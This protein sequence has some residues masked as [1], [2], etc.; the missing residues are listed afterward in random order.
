MPYSA[1]SRTST[2]GITGSKPVPAQLLERLAHERELEQHEVALEVGEARARRAARRAPCR[3][4]ARRARGGRGRRARPRRPRAARC[5]R[6]RRVVVGQ[7][8]QRG[9]R[10]VE[11][12]PRPRLSL[13]AQLARRE[14]RSAASC[15]ALLGV[16]ARPCAR[17]WPR[18]ARPAAPRARAAARASARRAPA[19][20][21]AAA[22][23]S[24]RRR[25]SAARTA[26]GSR[27]ISLRSS[28]ARAALRRS[29]RPV[30]L[31]PSAAGRARRGR[32]G[33]R[34]ATNFASTASS[35]TTMFCGMIAPG[36][37]AVA[38]RV[39]HAVDVLVALV[40]VRA[41]V[42]ARACLTLVAEPWVPAA[43]S[44]WQPEQCW[45]NERRAPLGGRDL[46]LGAAGRGDD[47]R[48]AR[49]PREQ[50]RTG[51]NRAGA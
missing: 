4:A 34:S 47:A 27:R 1:C 6:R 41:V 29:R 35:P 43:C 12:A 19:P 25:A 15:L 23:A 45:T 22:A 11:L 2:G 33:R 21:P 14:P 8:G 18:S 32:F 9:Q 51:S 50:A 20:G 44:V 17:G 3:S 42:V 26:S 39:E 30:Q 37:A 49:A 24:P 7:V 28:T 40:E 46:R 38:D 5:P 16:G 13:V 36:E 48:H 10:R 31:S